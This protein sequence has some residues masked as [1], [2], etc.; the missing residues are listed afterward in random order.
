[1]AD[2]IN[3]LDILTLS[4]IGPDTVVEKFSSVTNSSFFDA[5]NILGGLKIKGLIDFTTSFPG[6]SVVHVTDAG[7]ATLA[8]AEEKSKS[9][10]LDQLDLEILLQLSKGKRTLTDLGGAV[11]IRARDLGMH[12]YKLM[13]QQFI[14]STLK[15]GGIDITLTEKG[16]LSVKAQPGTG[17]SSVQPSGRTPKE[18][19]AAAGPTVA[20]AQSQSGQQVN[21][22]PPPQNL[23]YLDKIIAGRKRKKTMM[24]IAVVIV[25]IVVA[26]VAIKFL[27]I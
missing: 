11:N 16:F 18:P 12:L 26:V 15:N 6:Q 3:F 4:K 23:D 1:M 10:E 25:V 24:I 2:E 9:S 20:S 21:A 22:S 27:G 14:S 19:A 8:E 17:A 5:S 13:E 7:V